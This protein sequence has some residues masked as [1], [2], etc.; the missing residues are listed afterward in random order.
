MADLQWKTVKDFPNI[1]VSNTGIVINTKRGTIVKGS[2]TP[3][4]YK[5]VQLSIMENNNCRKKNYY[6]H[7][8]VAECFIEDYSAEKDVHH[9]DL[10][11]SNNNISNLQCLTKEEHF[12]IHN[13]LKLERNISQ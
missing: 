13:K 7:R 8:L 2:T 1:K 9:I 10:D 12:E 11:K 4:G 6:L 5:T 3:K